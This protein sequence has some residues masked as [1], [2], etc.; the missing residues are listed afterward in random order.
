MSKQTASEKLESKIK[1]LEKEVAQLRQ[2]EKDLAGKNYRLKTM[3]NVGPAVIYTSKT[4][5]DFGATFLSEN[6]TKQLGYEPHEFTENPQFWSDNIHP[7]DRS[8]VFSGLD[9]LLE[10]GFHTHE[11][12][13]KNKVGV[14]KWMR[15]EIVVVNDSKGKPIEL[16]GFWIDITERKQAEIELIKRETLLKDI[17][18]AIQ[19]GISVLDT[20]FNVI[21][22][23]KTMREWYA[24]KMPFEGKQKCYEVYHNRSAPCEVCPSLR[25]LKSKKLE[26][27]EVFYVKNE[28]MAGTLELF[29][30]PIIDES[31]EVTGVVEYVRD[32]TAQKNA[33]KDKTVLESHL[34][35]AHKMEAIGT[36]T[37]GIAHD[38]NNT[39]AIILGNAELASLTI[40]DEHP[41][42]SNIEQVLNASNR[43]KDLIRNLL[44]FSRK[45]DVQKSSFYLCRLVDECMKTLRSTIP[46]SVKLEV[47]IPSKCRG[48]FDECLMI[49]ADPTQFH[50]LL[51][52]LCVNA[53]DAMD[54]KGTL[55]VSLQEV[56]FKDDIP[57]NRP[58]VKP[59]TYEYL[60][61]SD[62]G[63]GVKPELIEK[64]FDPF[65]TTKEV[66]KGTGMGLSVVQGI[67]KSH[68]GYIYIESELA[69]GTTFHMY[70]PA[71]KGSTSET[72]HDEK[73]PFPRGKERI[74]FVDDEKEVADVGKLML[75]GLGY[76]VTTIIKSTEALEFFKRDSNRFDLV[77]TDQSMPNMLGTELAQQLLQI[78]PDI[79][80]ILCTGY[81]SKVNKEEVR[82]FGIK[83]FAMKPL[84]NKELAELIR[85]VLDGEK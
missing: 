48:S 6:I 17:L 43:A 33:E 78:R 45:D 7:E 56:T 72:L 82:Q 61:V 51:M 25:T 38:F 77:I 49:E 64:I 39:L 58:G 62:T 65:F 20:N 10:E 28:G 23:N 4:F 37:G 16:I 9:N 5:G 81:S 46:K 19:D 63:H 47:N 26:K 57:A 67:I 13:F 24:H 11:Y 54:D 27:E 40:S 8:K 50:Q 53:V 32:I 18:D 55:R 85:Q 68:D 73:K 59:G 71:T 35:Q 22:V 3:L 30:Y 66:D 29:T 70:F 31:G 76:S 52:N 2:S 60:K 34:R 15:D 21:Q 44:T 79:P 41:A 80:I 42:K 1:D 14:Y 75:E 12:R 74:L 84:S 83:A 69:K 36:L